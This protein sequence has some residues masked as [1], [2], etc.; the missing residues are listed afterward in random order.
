[1]DEEREKNENSFI[2]NLNQE[3]LSLI[4][5][6]LILE[7]SRYFK[8]KE[9]TRKADIEYS[10]R[11]SPNYEVTDFSFL[12]NKISFSYIKGTIIGS[13]VELVSYATPLIFFLKQDFNLRKNMLT[14]F[15]ITYL[16]LTTR[17]LIRD[18]IINRR[19]KE[20]ELEDILRQR[21]KEQEEYL[22]KR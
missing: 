5:G 13:I 16:A 3:I 1:M 14:S 19:L 9:E 7:F 21:I 10:I 17:S 2:K 20:S 6:N 18:D 11:K 12:K 22:N 15:A 4:P 8:Q